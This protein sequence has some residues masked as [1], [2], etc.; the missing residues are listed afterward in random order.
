[1]RVPGEWVPD[2]G[3]GASGHRRGTM[4]G[5]GCHAAAGRGG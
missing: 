3:R 2:E 1:M 5:G 4:K